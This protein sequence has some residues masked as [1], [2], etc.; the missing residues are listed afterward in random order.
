MSLLQFAVLHIGAQRSMHCNAGSIPPRCNL[1]S[2]LGLAND[3]NGLSI[4]HF[5]KESS[6]QAHP[7]PRRQRDFHWERQKTGNFAGI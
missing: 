5:R 7:L 4:V 3:L 6:Q 1:D 2:N